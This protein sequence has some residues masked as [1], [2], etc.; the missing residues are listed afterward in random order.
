MH[1]DASAKI[2]ALECSSLVKGKQMFDDTHLTQAIEAAGIAGAVAL[3]GGRDGV[4][5]ERVW[6]NRESGG[7]SPM[8]QDTLFNIA[9][10]T[11]AITSIAALQLVERGQL[12]LDAPVGEILPELDGLQVIE[13]FADDGSPKLRPAHV[14]ITLRHLLTH[15]SGMGYFFMSPD[16]MG[17]IAK[18]GA[19]APN[20]IASISLPLLFDPGVSWE[21]G[22][23]TDWAGR[24]I[25]A[26]S[27]MRLGAYMYAHIFEPLGLSD[28]GF[29]TPDADRLAALYSRAATG[30][31]EP[32]PF[33]GG[34]GPDREFDAGGSGLFS[35]AP[36]YFRFLRMIMN[37]GML[38][39]VRIL[40]EAGI[41]L[42]C[43]NQI[44]TLSAGVTN[45][46]LPA[47]ANVYEPFPGMSCGW[48]LGFLV[49][50]EPGPN[51]RRA[52]SLSW[53]GLPNCY[54]WLDPA[55]D[56]AGVLMAQLLPFGDSRMI[57]VFSALERMAYGLD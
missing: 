20:S 12:S 44:G 5:Y 34:S 33:S 29:E 35:T 30:G 39:G 50:P 28:T 40:G 41:A 4:R 49:N 21:Y 8:T 27:G 54:Y 48:S 25:E 56:V 10:M 38:D 17:V 52:G 26:A 15:T 47:L 16:L 9:S 14:R 57:D 23:S 46:A 32:S 37:G 7:G 1:I 3:I 45:S 13:G 51:G 53:A 2:V 36:D 22:T 55:A 6:G 18:Q 19:P 43:T 11:K 24:A 31:I 42:L